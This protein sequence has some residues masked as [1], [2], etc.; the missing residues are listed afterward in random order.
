MKSNL[1]DYSATLR[2]IISSVL[3]IKTTLRYE[4]KSFLCV[5]VNAR[6]HIGCAHCM[7]GSQ[8]REKRSRYNTLSKEGIDKVLTLIEDSN[9]RY[10]LLSSAGE[11]FLEMDLVL[12]LLEGAGVDV[13]WVV[14]S[15]YWGTRLDKAETVVAKLFKS[16]LVGRSV[17]PHRMVVLRISV[18]TYHVSK[19]GSP[20]DKFRHIVNIVSV[21]DSKY[22]KETNFKLL[23]HSLEGDRALIEEL[24][25]AL[26]ARIEPSPSP[27]FRDIKNP[28]EA[29]FI[30]LESGYRIEVTFAKLLLAD[31]C[32]DIRDSTR[33][34]WALATFDRDLYGSENGNPALKL[35]ED[36]TYGAN[37]LVWYDGSVSFGWQSEM[38]D[39]NLNI[40]DH[41]FQ[42]IRQ[43]SLSDPGTLATLEKGFDY[44]ARIVSEVNPKAVV[45]AKAVNIRDYTSIVLLEEHKTK[46]YYCIRVLQDYLHSDRICTDDLSALPDNIKAALDLQQR[47]LAALYF[48]SD[49]DIVVQSMEED[50]RWF[51]RLVALIKE[52][53]AGGTFA[54]LERFFELHTELTLRKIETWR[55]LLLRL[56][57]GW[58]DVSYFSCDEIAYLPPVVHVIEKVIARQ[59]R[60]PYPTTLSATNRRMAPSSHPNV[61]A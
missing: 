23:I 53:P 8:L 28:G 6:C 1:F 15:G 5:L 13:A 44:R 47:D 10:L 16:A 22:V 34:E 61:S 27:E 39:L 26:A 59:S 31:Q 52:L 55:L 17:A 20:G 40:Y 29:V 54:H 18:D 9:T 2:S 42:E 35:N 37:M 48:A 58:Y 14:T 60:R 4:G 33:I 11:S 56:I 7:F 49:F 24:A 21:F 38:P 32:V 12:R 51:A 19:L 30:V 46:L 3:T 41:S 43:K 36:E 57:N 25:E 50:P 45:R